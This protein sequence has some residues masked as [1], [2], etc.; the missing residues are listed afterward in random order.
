MCFGIYFTANSAH[1]C[2]YL[3]KSLFLVCILAVRH[4]NSADGFYEYFCKLVTSLYGGY[5]HLSTRISA[6]ITKERSLTILFPF[7]AFPQSF[8]MQHYITEGVE[9][10]LYI[11][12]FHNKLIFNQFFVAFYVLFSAFCSDSKMR[13]SIS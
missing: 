6:I 9:V 2:L 10:L 1:D 11:M 4:I 8:S 3:T 13:H 5:A 7:S 12:Y